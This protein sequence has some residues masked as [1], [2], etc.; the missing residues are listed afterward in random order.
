MALPVRNESAFT[1]GV[2]TYNPDDPFYVQPNR[3]FVATAGATVHVAAHP[4]AACK[5]GIRKPTYGS[6]GE[7][8]E[9]VV[10]RPGTIYATR[11]AT[12]TLVVRADLSV[13]AEIP[14][15]PARTRALK[16]RK[17]AK[18]ATKPRATKTA[19]KRKRKAAGGAKAKAR[20][21]R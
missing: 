11:P 6:L 19:V 4:N 2:F 8:R 15:E 20:R 12:C 10:E 17:N 9:D 18:N 3:V 5:V 16:T 1:L 13:A 14:L 21:A 7:L